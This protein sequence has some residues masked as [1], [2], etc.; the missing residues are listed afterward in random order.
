MTFITTRMD[1]NCLQIKIPKKLIYIIII[2]VVSC[3]TQW[4]K[5]ITIPFQYVKNQIILETT[6][7]GNNKKLYMLLD[8]GVDP[9]VIDFVTAEEIGLNINKG[10]EGDAS[11]RG[12][13]RASVY[14]T[15]M[16][17]LFIAG[18]NYGNIEGIARVLSGMNRRT[19]NKSRMNLAVQELET[20]YLS[21]ESEFTQFFEDL[22]LF[23]KKKYITLCED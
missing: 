20:F 1:F 4:G 23:S 18:R 15:Q 16:N 3:S 6:L 11:G 13:E 2:S 8:T 21:F 10:D 22:T 9:S 19:Q 17:A 14:P 7:N 5:S 12:N